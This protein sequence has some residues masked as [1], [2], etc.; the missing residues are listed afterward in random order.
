MENIEG[1]DWQEIEIKCSWHGAVS[2]VEFVCMEVSIES[3][4]G[5]VE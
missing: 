1:K 5:R 2:Y 4:E 3:I